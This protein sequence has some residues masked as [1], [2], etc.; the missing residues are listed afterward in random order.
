MCVYSITVCVYMVI[1]TSWGTRRSQKITWGCGFSPSTLWNLGLKLGSPALPL[2]AEAFHQFPKV[3]F[4]LY[5]IEKF[6]DS[7]WRG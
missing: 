7:G 3:Y 4:A 2:P 6:K 1:H 5:F